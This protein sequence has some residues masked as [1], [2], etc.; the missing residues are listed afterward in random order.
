MKFITLDVAKAHIK[1]TDPAYDG[2]VTLAL[3]HASAIVF[4]YI[5]ARADATWDETTAPP[6]VQRGTMVALAHLWEHRGDDIAP[7][8]HDEKLWSAL[9]LLF[10]RTRDPALA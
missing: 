4:D 10:M 8:A 2:E 7:D 1:V 6:I 5:G 9:S 3:E